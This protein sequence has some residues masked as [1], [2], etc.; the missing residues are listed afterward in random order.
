MKDEMPRIE[1][2]IEHYIGVG[3]EFSVKIISA[4]LVLVVGIFVI[5]LV[6]GI[7]KKII[8]KKDIDP[9]VSGFLLN[10]ISWL[11]KLLLFIAVV[12]KLGIETS[13]FVAVIGAMGLAIGL[14]LQGSLSNF[15]GGLLII[16]FKPFRVG[17]TITAQGITGTVVGIQ[18]FNTQVNT[19][20]NQAVFIPNGILSNGTVINFSKESQRRADIQINVATSNDLSRVNQIFLEV[21]KNNKKVLDTPAP[22]VVLTDLVGDWATFSIRPWSINSNF[23]DMSSEVLL[24]LKNTIEREQIKLPTQSI[25]VHNK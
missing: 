10:M 16:M 22:K 4:I 12:S 9:T 7:I 17:D 13:S 3:Q 5:R 21:L 2:V 11:F 24:E 20:N 25:E 1:K 15:T 14:S 8:A 18:V 6:R 23:S 19:S